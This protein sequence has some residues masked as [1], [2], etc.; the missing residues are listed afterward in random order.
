MNSLWRNAKPVACCLTS[1]FLPSDPCQFH[2]HLYV[3]MGYTNVCV[4]TKVVRL[5]EANTNLKKW[6][7]Q[8]FMIKL[9][10][11]CHPPQTSGVLL[12]SELTTDTSGHE[13]RS[14]DNLE[15]KRLEKIIL[16]WNQLWNFS[17]YDSN[18]H[19]IDHDLFTQ[20]KHTKPDLIFQ[21]A[22]H[23]RVAFHF[24]CCCDSCR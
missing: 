8:S 10:W 22:I 24:L 1:C 6:W 9:T 18:S 11:S 19:L 17:D 15:Q 3:S 7:Q 21:L 5:S 16:N 13:A 12:C 14:Q 20:T 4:M 2:A 23:S